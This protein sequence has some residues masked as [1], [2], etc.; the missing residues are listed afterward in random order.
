LGACY[1][2]MD[3]LKAVTAAAHKLA[4]LIYAMLTHGQEYTDRGQDYFEERYRQRVLHNLA[5][6]ARTMGMQLVPSDNTA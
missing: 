3:N 4:R 5:Q 1:R 2:R 6:K